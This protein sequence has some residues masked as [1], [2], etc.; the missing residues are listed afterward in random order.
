MA[1]VS[2]GWMTLYPSTV[3][4]GYRYG[5]PVDEKSVIHPTK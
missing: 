1:A 5:L 4:I 3:G 2:V